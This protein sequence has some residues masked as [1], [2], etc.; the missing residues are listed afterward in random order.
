MLVIFGSGCLYSR[1][2]L[3]VFPRLSSVACPRL[4]LLVACFPALISGCILSP[5]RLALIPYI[6]TLGSRSGHSGCAEGHCVSFQ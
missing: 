1:G 5:A 6:P 2:H 3:N 4:A